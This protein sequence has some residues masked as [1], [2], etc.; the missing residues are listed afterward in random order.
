[1][2]EREQRW[3][4]VLAASMRLNE[5]HRRVFA[6]CTSGSPPSAQRLRSTARFGLCP[7]RYGGIL[8]LGEV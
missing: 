6:D 4:D 8:L 2:P 1:M 5:S 7:G 3:S